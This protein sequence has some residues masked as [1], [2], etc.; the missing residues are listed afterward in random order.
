MWGDAFDFV[1]FAQ[2]VSQ[3]ESEPEVGIEAVRELSDGQEVPVD[4][5]VSEFADDPYM[6]EIIGNF[7]VNLHKYCDDLNEAVVTS[8]REQLRRLG[9]NI[10]GSAGG[11][12]FPMISEA[13]KVVENMIKDDSNL[14]DIAL[15]VDSLVTLCRRAVGVTL[16]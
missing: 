10:A 8:N 1:P 9:H 16:D 15:E 2:R 7:V 13:A 3:A 5:I 4:A 12:G 11:Y 6:K 14:D